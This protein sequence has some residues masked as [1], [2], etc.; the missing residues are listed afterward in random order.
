[1]VFKIL[2]TFKNSIGIGINQNYCK[3]IIKGEKSTKLGIN[4]RLYLYLKYYIIN[5]NISIPH[6]G[7]KYS[8]YLR[9]VHITPFELLCIG[10]Y[11]QHY[12]INCCSVFRGVYVPPSITFILINIFEMYGFGK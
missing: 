10:Y 12:Y 5:Y 11:V 7:N 2:N 1:M 8:Y 3:F 9:Y 4:H 6:T